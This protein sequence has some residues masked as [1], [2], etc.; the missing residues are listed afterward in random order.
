MEKFQKIK[1]LNCV[2]GGSSAM[3]FWNEFMDTD[4]EFIG[5]EAGGPKIAN[6][7]QLHYLMVKNRNLH[8]AAQYVVQDKEGQIGSTELFLLV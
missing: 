1:L 2:G 8:G 6:Y 3:G 4:A 5:I 7:M